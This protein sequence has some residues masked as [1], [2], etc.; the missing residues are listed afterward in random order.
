MDNISFIIRYKQ[1]FG[2]N[3][4]SEFIKMNEMINLLLDIFF[5]YAFVNFNNKLILNLNT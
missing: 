2:E 5:K 4:W 3:F 1:I